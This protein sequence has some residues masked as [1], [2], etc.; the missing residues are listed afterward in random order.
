MG[1]TT[2]GVGPNSVHSSLY[3][4]PGALILPVTTFSPSSTPSA[5]HRE[6]LAAGADAAAPASAAGSSGILSG[7]GLPLFFVGTGGIVGLSLLAGCVWM[8][9]QKQRRAGGGGKGGSN[10]PLLSSSVTLQPPLSA[11]PKARQGG[12][13]WQGKLG[14]K[15][16]GRGGGRITTTVA[17]QG[18]FVYQGGLTY[19]PLVAAL[20]TGGRRAK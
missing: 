6:A 4:L 12:E 19:N 20:T 18:G 14:R 1:A 9:A 7:P 11:P 5:T 8:M 15:H 3:R 13:R 17:P 10:N 2:F 16:G